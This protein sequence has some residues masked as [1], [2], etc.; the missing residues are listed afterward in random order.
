MYT[1]PDV[2]DDGDPA[3]GG[4]EN[5]A[6]ENHAED[7]A[8]DFALRTCICILPAPERTGAVAKSFV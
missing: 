6:D 7:L 4:D 2:L 3:C 1:S 8:E 5:P